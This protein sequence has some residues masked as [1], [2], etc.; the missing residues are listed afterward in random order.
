MLNNGDNES[1]LLHFL[2]QHLVLT[3]L[4]AVAWP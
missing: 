3:A 4:L 1:S 2:K